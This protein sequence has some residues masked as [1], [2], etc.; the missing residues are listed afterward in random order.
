MSKIWTEAVQGLSN[1]SHV[2]VLGTATVSLRHLEAVC[3][4]RYM[5]VCDCFQV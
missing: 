3:W 4:C 1:G 5:P 2:W